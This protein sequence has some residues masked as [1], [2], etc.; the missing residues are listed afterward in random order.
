MNRGT[1]VGRRTKKAEEEKVDLEQ[2]LRF[3]PESSA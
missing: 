3:G 1:N 2:K